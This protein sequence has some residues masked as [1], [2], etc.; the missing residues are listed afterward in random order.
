[1]GAKRGRGWKIKEEKIEVFKKQKKTK[2][3]TFDIRFE[4][5]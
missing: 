1:M 3:K 4:H 2:K 5:Y